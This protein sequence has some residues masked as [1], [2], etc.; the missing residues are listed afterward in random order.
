MT[1]TVDVTGMPLFIKT[2]QRESALGVYTI[3]IKTDC[4][5]QTFEYTPCSRVSCAHSQY[6]QYITPNYAISAVHNP[7]LLRTHE[8]LYF[9]PR[10]W[11]HVSN[12]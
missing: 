5:Q 2:R 9:T 8:V 11:E 1:S 12:F 6:P 3:Y 4:F 10:Y 7:E